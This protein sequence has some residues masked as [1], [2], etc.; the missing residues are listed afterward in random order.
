MIPYST[1]PSILYSVVFSLPEMHFHDDP[2]ALSGALIL[3]FLRVFLVVESISISIRIA[4]SNPRS[5][6]S[7]TNVFHMKV[8]I[9]YLGGPYLLFPDP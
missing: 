1:I 9:W 5:L 8:E 3:A 6:I 2:S 4:V 7:Y